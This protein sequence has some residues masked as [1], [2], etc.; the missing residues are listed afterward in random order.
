MTRKLMLV[1]VVVLV[2]RGS[3]AQ[4]AI[5]I[6]LSFFFFSL[7]LSVAPFKLNQDNM[8]RASTECHV[9]LVL[10]AALMMRTEPVGYEDTSY[11]WI[12]S[13]TFILLVPGAFVIT[14]V[15]KIR[16]ALSAQSSTGVDAAFNR[17]RL[18]LAIGGDC[19][20]LFSHF[21]QLRGELEPPGMR[22]WRNKELVT[23]LEP[24]QLEVALSELGNRL[25]KSQALGYHFTDIDSARLILH[26]QGIRAST[27][28][29]L[30]GGV[31]VCLTSPVEL[32]WTK[33]SGGR[34]AKRVGEALWGSLWRQIMS[35]TAPEGGFDATS[36][37]KEL[38]RAIYED[39]APEKLS[40]VDG[41]LTANEGR[42]DELLASLREKYRVEDR[43]KV[44]D[45]NQDWGKAANKLEVLL[46]LQIPSEEN[47][48]KTRIV[49]GRPSIYIIPRADCAPGEGSDTTNVYLPNDK[50]E[51]V[52]ILRPPDPATQQ[53]QLDVMVAHMEPVR[54]LC[55]SDRDKNGAMKEV[56]VVEM[57]EL[58]SADDKL[59][60]AHPAKPGCPVVAAFTAAVAR[61]LDASGAS[62]RTHQQ[63]Q[64]ANSGKMLWPENIARFS[65]DEM[66]AAVNTIDQLAP[67]AYTLG[68]F[69]TSADQAGELFKGSKGLTASKQPDGGLGI[70]VSLRNPA[71]LGWEKNAGGA[72]LDTAGNLLFGPHWRET[73][74]KQLQAVLILGIPTDKMPADGAETFVIPEE[75]MVMEDVDEPY[76]SSAHVYKS[77][78]LQRTTTA[79]HCS[80]IDE[81]KDLQ[82]LF[83]R[84]DA[85]GDGNVTKEEAKQYLR[86]E[87]Q[88]DLD[89]HSINVIWQALDEDESGDLDITEFP[90]FLEVVDKEIARVAADVNTPAAQ[91]SVVQTVQKAAAQVESIEMDDEQ[92][93]GLRV[94]VERMQAKLPTAPTAEDLRKE[95]NGLKLKQLQAR[96]RTLGI[97]EDRIEQ[98]EE[99]DNNK[100][101][102]IELVVSAT[103]VNCTETG[104]L[105][106]LC[107]LLGV[108]PGALQ[109]ALGSDDAAAAVRNMLGIDQ[110]VSEALP[111]EEELRGE[112]SGLRLKQLQ[113][114][115]RTLGIEED[116]IEEA[117]ETDN[118]KAALVELVVSATPVS[119]TTAQS[120]GDS[121]L[122]ELCALL[123]ID[124]EALQRALGSDGAEAAVL[125][126]L[127]AA[128]AA[129][130]SSD[131]VLASLQAGGKSLSDLVSNV[132]E[133]A[134]EVLEQ[135]TI[136]S[137]RKARR[138]VRDIIDRAEAAL[139]SMDDA[140]CDAVSR[141]DELSRLAQLL[142]HVQ[143]S[144][145]ESSG[146]GTSTGMAELLDCLDQCASALS[147]DTQSSDP[148][149]ASLQ[150]GG[151]SLSDLVSNVLEGAVEV[152]E[153]HTITS[154][155][156]A[157]RPVRDIID[158]AEAALDSMDDAW[159][160][161]VSRS[162]ELSRLAQLLAHVQSS[163]AESSGPGTSTG[164]AELLDCLDRCISA[165][166]AH[167]VM[168]PEPEP[169]PEAGPSWSAAARAELQS[170]RPSA[171]KQRAVAAGVSASDFDDIDDSE[172]PTEAL[173]SAILARDQLSSRRRNLDDPFAASVKTGTDDS[174]AS[175]Y[176][177][178][179]PDESNDTP[180]TVETLHALLADGTISEDTR[181][182]MEGMQTWLPIS[183]C[184][185]LL[186]AST[187]RIER[188]GHPSPLPRARSPPPSSSRN[189]HTPPRNR[190]RE[191]VLKQEAEPTL[192]AHSV[193]AAVDESPNIPR[194]RASAST[195][196]RNS[197]GKGRPA[198]L[199]AT[200]GL[201]NTE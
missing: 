56:T 110:T 137:P 102:I 70:R 61:P 163:T 28:G 123:S 46:V 178:V 125:R 154:P 106:E 100:A 173:I 99:A 152:L 60:D 182:W 31:S 194:R 158:R 153:Q 200:G 165:A 32:G 101:A 78:L 150:A 17:F 167:Q 134:V 190:S 84:V 199:M 65:T 66:A 81:E 37:R 183:E 164:M 169:E 172:D 86:K 80:A 36:L 186:P 15:S 91:M 71:E 129:E 201:R 34:F 68:Y 142:A 45:P 47:R 64:E 40:S 57:K 83:A 151:K 9:F 97:D 126:L 124:A 63:I 16:F 185:A 145:A 58:E 127:P 160:D 24:G 33:F 138:P 105:S 188:P 1:G 35:G 196:P 5:A 175:V 193:G 144:T 176:Y 184:E 197:R 112:L 44:E 133:G 187:R 20:T 48:V 96:V 69:F 180:V 139:D 55:K 85:N 128:A 141:S 18:G 2:G 111:T 82:E 108:N 49:P 22:L 113:A 116:R 107:A 54:V 103:P 174:I 119:S 162:D 132:L 131:P 12:L 120:S 11:D 23:H 26:G 146:P 89:D 161:A 94:A 52:F 77:Y 140:W 166:P 50:I 179:K 43:Y 14:V 90:R 59:I 51:Q 135:H 130:G 171:R 87:R 98:A 147:S 39:H 191:Q 168:V 136:A 92:I 177:E 25:P 170:M 189:S 13:G 79:D 29:Q 88:V 93:Q 4:L 121:S 159:C 114:R 53:K 115:V 27:V 157:R 8:F 30:G 118:N 38:V 21:E 148:V 198:T 192:V 67:Q 19:A 122:S 95:L 181:C 6:V 156:K 104:S 42:E 3:S 41:L 76:Y 73:N 143:S 75:L 195:P 117:E 74:D 72:F 62:M 7:Q 109:D 149:L 10:V 155:R